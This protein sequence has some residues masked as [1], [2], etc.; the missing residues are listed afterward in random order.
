MK[1][2]VMV[3][4]QQHLATS[5]ASTDKGFYFIFSA[6]SKEL[7]AKRQELDDVN[8]KQ[9]GLA[10]LQTDVAVMKPDFDLI[11]DR[12]HGFAEIWSSV[13][14][15]HL[16]RTCLCRRALEQVRSQ[17]VQFRTHIQGGLAAATNSV[18]LCCR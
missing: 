18:R 16:S 10:K 3:S 4:S 12:L 17:S 11:C 5:S 7:T 6:K 9:K 2:S 13:S 1:T 8:R 15:F 14:I